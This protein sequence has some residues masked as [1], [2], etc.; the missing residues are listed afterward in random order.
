MYGTTPAGWTLAG[1]TV[2]LASTLWLAR[3]ESR[4]A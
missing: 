1:G 2:I 3:Q 4:P